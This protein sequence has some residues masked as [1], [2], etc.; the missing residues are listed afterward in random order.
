MITSTYI[1]DA[2]KADRDCACVLGNTLF[3]IA[4]TIGVATYNGY[5]YGFQS[6]ANQG[7]FVNPLPKCVDKYQRWTIP[8]NY[9]GYDIG[10][11]GFNIPDNIDIKAQ[12][13]SD[14]YWRHCEGLIRHFL[15]MKPLCRP[16][17]DTIIIQ[18]RAYN[19]LT[20]NGEYTKLTYDNYYKKALKL[21][22]DKN[23]ICITND[24]EKAMKAVNIDCQYIHASPIIDFY[25]LT[26]ADYII[27]A[28]SSFS[29]WGAYLSKAKTVAP[30]NWFTKN[31]TDCPLDDYY[32]DTWIKC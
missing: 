22:P 26:Q 19:E 10:F 9:K 8:T 30:K 16:I 31:W 28:N 17:K 5:S 27:M 3:N 1:R 29:W 15:T 4:G 6:W 13:G 2:L 11:R 12:F 25:L 24:V 32:I 7:Y 14:K 18:Y 21:M 23:I 20:D